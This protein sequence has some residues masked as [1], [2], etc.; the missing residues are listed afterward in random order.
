M[1]MKKAGILGSGI[2]GR[3][4]ALGLKEEGFE[5]TIGSRTP[6]KLAEWQSSDGKGVRL[7]SFEESVS[8]A[9]LVV[10]A[11][12]GDAANDVVASLREH[13]SGKTI[14]DA[15]NP[16]S[17]EPPENGVIKFFTN[18]NS[19][20]MEELQNTAPQANFVKA[21]NSIGNAYMVN[22]NFESKPSMFYCGNNDEAKAE[23]KELL[24]SFGFEPEDMGGAEAARAIEPLCILWCIPGFN[25]GRWSHA[26]KLLKA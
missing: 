7:G 12:K 17:S 18:A 8:H 2:V 10:L 24:T 19:S 5:V 3:T 14:I 1:N 20:L 22:P 13:L 21:F 6:G 4:L 15:T 9:E 23:V 11:V 16:I 25:E 26:F